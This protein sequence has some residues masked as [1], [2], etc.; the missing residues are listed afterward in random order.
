MGYRSGIKHIF[1]HLNLIY[2]PFISSRYS[3]LSKSSSLWGRINRRS[4]DPHSSGAMILI[5]PK[6]LPDR[7]SIHLLS[8]SYFNPQVTFSIAH[9]NKKTFCCF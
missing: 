7:H 9:S 3:G 4:L 8:G 6:A 1:Q 5:V 2:L